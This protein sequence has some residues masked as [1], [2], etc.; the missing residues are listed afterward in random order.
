M[1]SDGIASSGVALGGGPHGE[2]IL[3]APNPTT[4]APTILSVRTG[5]P[6]IHLIASIAAMVSLDARPLIFQ[7]NDMEAHTRP[8]MPEQGGLGP[9]I[10]ALRMTRRAAAAR[11]PLSRLEVRKGL[12]FYGHCTDACAGPSL[13]VRGTFK[14]CWPEVTTPLRRYTH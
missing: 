5:R 13:G 2:A 8:S 3:L 4:T 9:L 7:P 6:R 10:D 1:N 14:S 12:G 11:Q